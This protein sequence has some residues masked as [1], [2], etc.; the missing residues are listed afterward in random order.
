MK[1]SFGRETYILTARGARSRLYL[2]FGVPND[3]AGTLN[4]F[5]RGDRGMATILNLGLGYV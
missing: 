1:S 3:F 2:I 5:V 4:T